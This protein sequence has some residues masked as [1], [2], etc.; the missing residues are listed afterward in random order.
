MFSY[1][2]ISPA[3]SSEI[4]NYVSGEISLSHRDNYEDGCLY[5]NTD[6]QVNDQAKVNPLK[7]SGNYVY[8]LL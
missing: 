6:V 5:K 7:Q 8:R 1:C 2:S 3:T 4:R